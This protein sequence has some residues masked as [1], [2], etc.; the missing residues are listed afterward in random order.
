[1]YFEFVSDWIG[2][3]SGTN[4]DGYRIIVNLDAGW[5]NAKFKVD[6]TNPAN[7]T[8]TAYLQGIPWQTEFSGTMGT[9]NFNKIAMGSE[10]KMSIS[11]VPDTGK[12]C[13]YFLGTSKDRIWLV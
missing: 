5:A 13:A 2:F 10:P 8:V 7:G 12:S 3:Q 4:L 9:R 1:M 11:R 6:R